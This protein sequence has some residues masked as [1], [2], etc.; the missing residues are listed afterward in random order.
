MQ[1]VDI[2]IQRWINQHV[3]TWKWEENA[4]LCLLHLIILLEATYVSTDS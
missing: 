1:L 2:E 4:V 3:L